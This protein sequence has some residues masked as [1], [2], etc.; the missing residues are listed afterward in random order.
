M[1]ST[2]AGMVAA[3]IALAGPGSAMQSAAAQLTT[4]QTPVSQASEAVFDACEAS[5]DEVDTAMDSR[6]VC[7]CIVGYMGA[8]LTDRDYVLFGML[9]Q[10]AYLQGSGA[11]Q[12]ELQLMSTKIYASGYTDQDI[13]A[14]INWMQNSGAA[15]R[16]VEV[17][18]MFQ[19]I[20]NTFY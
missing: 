4:Y 7:A 1:K 20:Q 3:I 5:V 8:S 18:A 2:V 6:Q 16:S 17:C 12:A 13:L 15:A 11:S 19:Q 10:V 9:S 14:M